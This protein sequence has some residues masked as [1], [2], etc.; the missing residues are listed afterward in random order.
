MLLPIEQLS[1][2]TIENV[3]PGCLLWS[4]GGS[5]RT[6]FWILESEASRV[7]L[8]LSGDYTWQ[9]FRIGDGARWPGVQ[10]GP[11]E[12][13]VDLTSAHDGRTG[14]RGNL[15][16]SEGALVLFVKLDRGGFSE[17]VP[18]RLA[19]MKTLEVGSLHFKQW[20]LGMSQDGKW[21]DLVTIKDGAIGGPLVSAIS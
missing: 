4:V 21:I 8:F 2:S 17:T 10:I 18:V 19:D 13:R 9:G 20:T 7:A 11:V 3:R 12:V 5:E 1:I 6:L 16:A 15:V 14:A